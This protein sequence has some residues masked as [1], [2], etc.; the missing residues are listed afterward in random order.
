MGAR[1]N[2]PSERQISRL[3]LLITFTLRLINQFLEE[4]NTQE[5]RLKWP[6][7][8]KRKDVKNLQE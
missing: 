6:K 3:R 4:K 2:S 7:V 5:L 8:S 1:S